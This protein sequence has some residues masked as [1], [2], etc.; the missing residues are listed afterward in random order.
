MTM[1]ADVPE[2][3]LMGMNVA[4]LPGTEDPWSFTILVVLM[5]AIGSGILL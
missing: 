1:S 4:G 5:L 3:G 2:R